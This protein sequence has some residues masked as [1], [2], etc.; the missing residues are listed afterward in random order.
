MQSLSS[1]YLNWAQLAFDHLNLDYAC[2][3]R[4]GRQDCSRSDVAAIEVNF[5]NFVGDLF[6]FF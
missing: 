3:D 6:E 1:F 4:L 2:C 5:G